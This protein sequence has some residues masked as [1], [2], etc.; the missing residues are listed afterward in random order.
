MFAI[1]AIA[2]I[3]KNKPKAIF[4]L[5]LIKIMLTIPAI[6]K[7]MK[8]IRVSVSFKETKIG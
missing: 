8:K 6:K 2:K 3:V 5:N 4:L 7:R 1:G